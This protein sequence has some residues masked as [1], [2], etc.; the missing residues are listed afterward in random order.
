MT[1]V[2]S[3]AGIASPSS[4]PAFVPS[5][6]CQYRWFYT[7][8]KTK[9]KSTLRV[10]ALLPKEVSFE[11]NRRFGVLFTPLSRIFQLYCGSQL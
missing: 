11:D 7:L 5:F 10:S 3:R 4:A 1:S 6:L 2:T 8:L 9:L